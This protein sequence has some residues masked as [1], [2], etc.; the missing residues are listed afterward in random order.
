MSLPSYI[1]KL[2]AARVGS[3]RDGRRGQAF[4]QSVSRSV[5]EASSCCPKNSFQVDWLNNLIIGLEAILELL[6]HN[7]SPISNPS[8]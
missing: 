8:L 4:S 1:K 6:F 5:V 7:S 2:L 3:G